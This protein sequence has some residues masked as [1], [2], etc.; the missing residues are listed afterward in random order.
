MN[1]K[2]FNQRI[3]MSLL[4][5]CAWVW[6]CCMRNS[7]DGK[8]TFDDVRNG[9]ISVGKFDKTPTGFVV[10]DMNLCPYWD[11]FD[12]QDIEGVKY[13]AKKE[14]ASLFI[15]YDKNGDKNLGFG[16]SYPMD[17]VFNV[18]RSLG[19]KAMLNKARFCQKDGERWAILP[20]VS[21]T[22]V[23]A[24][25]KAITKKAANATVSLGDAIMAAA[26]AIAA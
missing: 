8:F 23:K 16:C 10:T 3:T 4:Q 6:E 12:K 13:D 15:P 5:Q 24:K 14:R 25:K 18:A 7:G 17:G 22:K 2:E 1:Q 9:T 20:E 21:K 26:R 19:V 11:V